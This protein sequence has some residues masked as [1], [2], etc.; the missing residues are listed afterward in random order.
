MTDGERLDRL[1]ETVKGIR[2]GQRELREH[3]D[4]KI[5]A[6]TT[7]V[8]KS[9]SE[10]PLSAPTWAFLLMAASTTVFAAVALIFLADYYFF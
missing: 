4:D 10:Q 3:I 6:L 5:D 7:A 2:I 1:E 9:T 8:E